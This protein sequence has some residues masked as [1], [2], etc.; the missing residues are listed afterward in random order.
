VPSPGTAPAC[1]NRWSPDLR[2]SAEEAAAAPEAGLA[3]R[4]RARHAEIHAALARG[5]TI[6]EVSRTL[7]L[8]R[9]TI[10]RYAPPRPLMS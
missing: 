1:K 4:T 5:L 3:A 8:D 7:G 6:T 9:K 2:G 10:R